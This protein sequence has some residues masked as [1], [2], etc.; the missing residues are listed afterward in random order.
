MSRI[1][2]DW[3]KSDILS[4]LCTLFKLISITSS[5]GWLRQ[6]SC[7]FKGASIAILWKKNSK[8]LRNDACHIQAIVSS[9]SLFFSRE[10]GGWA[11]FLENLSQGKK[12][13]W[14]S[15]H[16]QH[17]YGT[18]MSDSRRNQKANVNYVGL[19][20]SRERGQ[21]KRLEILGEKGRTKGEQWKRGQGSRQRKQNVRLFFHEDWPNS[22]L[23]N[24]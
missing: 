2:Q 16:S 17:L 7:G 4:I 13:V 9:Y 15:P 11:E 8:Q 23:S 3:L 1:K 14:R 6:E 19:T 21:G 20:E 22:S 18:K 10:V 12:L 24:C 5:E